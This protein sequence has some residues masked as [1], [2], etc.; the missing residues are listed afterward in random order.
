MSTIT[1]NDLR[2]R[3]IGDWLLE[4]NGV[5]SN[6]KEILAVFD[7]LVHEASEWRE[8]GEDALSYWYYCKELES[9]GHQFSND[10]PSE[11]AHLLDL[12]PSKKTGATIVKARLWD[13]L[14]E[15][16]VEEDIW[17]AKAIRI[18]PI[19]DPNKPRNIRR[20][21]WIEDG[22]S[23]ADALKREKL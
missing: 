9:D 5:N 10:S 14:V 3:L 21:T 19:T 4:P 12:H 22:H 7:R 6:L 13:Q 18:P 20:L 11:F 23:I 15:L 16:S 2:E 1:P 17:I 8:L